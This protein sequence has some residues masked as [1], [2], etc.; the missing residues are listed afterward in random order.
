MPKTLGL[1]IKA[2][3]CLSC[4][5]VYAT[6]T[7]PNPQ[8]DAEAPEEAPYL[9]LVRELRYF[10][11]QTSREDPVEDQRVPVLKRDALP[12]AFYHGPA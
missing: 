4:F 8:C 3:R 1:K 6:T 12:R 7:P 2:E 10:S 5:Q 11:E 9:L